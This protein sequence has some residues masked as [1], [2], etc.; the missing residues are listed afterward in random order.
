M[1]IPYL[2]A[3][4]QLRICAATWM[5]LGWLDTT[6]LPKNGFLGNLS[7]LSG[8]GGQVAEK[9]DFPAARDNFRLP[10]IGE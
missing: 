8:P 10:V 6:S 3:V 5:W 9:G 4:D 1:G 7:S 2:S